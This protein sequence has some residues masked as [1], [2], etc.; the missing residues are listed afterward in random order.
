MKILSVVFTPWPVTLARW[1]RN[2]AANKRVRRLVT[3]VLGYLIIFLVVLPYG[4]WLIVGD[5]GK[6][7]IGMRATTFLGFTL[8]I[9]TTLLAILV[10]VGKYFVAF[11][12]NKWWQKCLRFLVLG[13]E[14][15]GL[16]LFT[17]VAVLA[18]G[19]GPWRFL[20]LAIILGMTAWLWRQPTIKKIWTTW[21][22][23][24][25]LMLTIVFVVASSAY[26]A[27]MIEHPWTSNEPLYPLF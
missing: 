23:L 27:T 8:L 22:R 11:P 5:R 17:F 25:F 7:V 15:I 24:V 12:R 13:V 20:I 10:S 2:P 6:L 3:L 26:L 9:L 21:V 19:L 16:F 18:N 14:G 4:L 1:W